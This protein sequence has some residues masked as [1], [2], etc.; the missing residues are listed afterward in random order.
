M[1]KPQQSKIHV[2][3]KQSNSQHGMRESEVGR[4]ER[5]NMVRKDS[6]V[7]VKKQECETWMPD[8]KRKEK[9]EFSFERAGPAQTIPTLYLFALETRNNNKKNPQSV[10]QSGGKS[11]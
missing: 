4:I 1:V 8:E 9:L 3:R 7:Q 6:T 11:R 2:E 10:W 5:M